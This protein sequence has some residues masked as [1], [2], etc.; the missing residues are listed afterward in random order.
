MNN[1]EVDT[2][3]LNEIIN[4][5]ALNINN[6]KEIMNNI[7]DC[8]LTLNE[9]KWVGREKDKIDSYYGV[10]LKRMLNFGTEMETNLN[11]LR[12]AANSYQDVEQATE[13]DMNNVE[14]L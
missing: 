10:Y 14:D 12:N 1:L 11:V 13:N 6:V 2:V 7:N 9:N 4:E 5:I 3:A 8:Y